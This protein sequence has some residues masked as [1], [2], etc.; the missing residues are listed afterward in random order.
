MQIIETKLFENDGTLIELYIMNNGKPAVRMSDVDM[1]SE[2][3][4]ITIYPSPEKA[5]S[6][7]D[8]LVAKLAEVGGC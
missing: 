8:A 3:I 6:G 7:F 4:G 2:F 5:R 1:P